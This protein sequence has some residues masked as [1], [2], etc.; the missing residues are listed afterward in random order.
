MPKAPIPNVFPGD[1]F[2][3]TWRR[4]T[5]SFLLEL[6]D[7]THSSYDLGSDPIGVV[8]MLRLRG[9]EKK[10]R[11]EAVD[12]S[13]EFGIAQCIPAQRRV[14]PVIPRTVP[15]PDIFAEE[16]TTDDWYPNL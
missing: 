11:E 12:L 1:F 15:K 9:F 3:L 5:E 7:E 8:Q 10:F 16:G 13:R 6:D 4:D 2:L 14:L